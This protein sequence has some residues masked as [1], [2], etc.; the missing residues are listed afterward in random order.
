LPDGVSEIVGVVKD[1]K[2]GTPRDDRGVIYRA[3]RQRERFLPANWCVAVRATGEPTALAAGVRQELRN[4]DPNL[5][6]LRINTIEQ[7]LDDVL[8]QERLIA[9]LSGLF[10]LLAVL[11]ACL[12]LYGVISYTVARRTSEIG[13]RLALGARQAGVLRMIL[14]ESLMLA[15]AGIVIGAPA[16]IA[17][18]RLISSRLFGVS[19][20]DPLTIAVAS[21]LMIAVAALAAFL[22]AYR[23]A[24]VDPMVALRCE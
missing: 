11:L 5:P 4:I 7:Q 16:T 20:A 1:A 17:I 3:Y 9:S 18:T 2:T 24:R 6:V 15:L 13:I 22:P 8:Y 23:A 10:A 19:A 14:K 21:L 12:G